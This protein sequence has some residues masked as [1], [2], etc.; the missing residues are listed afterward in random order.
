V[1]DLSV[2]KDSITLKL[3][4]ANK[5]LALKRK[6]EIPLDNIAKISL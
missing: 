6:I 2:E 5:F 3:E 1:V 4:E